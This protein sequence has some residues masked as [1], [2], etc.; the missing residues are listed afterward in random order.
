MVIVSIIAIILG[1][2]MCF[3]GYKLFRVWLAA[4]GLLL[5]A[6]AGHYLGGLLGG[7][8]WPVV[9]AVAVGILLALLSYFLYKVGAILIGALLGGML[10][11][12][13]LNALNVDAPW[14]VGLI[15]AVAGA[16]I[17]GVYL[18]LF[19]IIGS[20][21]SGAQLA[22]VGAYALI[23]NKD[24]LE[25]HNRQVLSFPWYVLAIILALAVVAVVAQMRYMKGHPDHT[26][27]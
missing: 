13:A 18:K 1:L 4:A 21:Y 22:V 3:F 20:S 19:I 6:Y 27:K 26:D 10:L 8:V 25:M 14:W 7:D 9:G 17:A 15:G 11:L 23:V 2:L 12:V 16:V 5:G 24:F